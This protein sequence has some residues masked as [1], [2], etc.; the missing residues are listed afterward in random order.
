MEEIKNEI[1][2][3][4]LSENNEMKIKIGNTIEYDISNGELK[5]N[6]E[7]KFLMG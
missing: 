1:K 7:V 3:R 2:F 6:G 4:V 5:Q